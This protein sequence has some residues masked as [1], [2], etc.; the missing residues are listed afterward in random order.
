MVLTSEGVGDLQKVTDHGS[1]PAAPS[2]TVLSE[3]AILAA[4]E[5]ND[6]AAPVP[7]TKR[8]VRC[9]F[10][11]RFCGPFVHRWFGRWL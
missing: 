9:A 8:H 7:Q 4:Q 2:V 5:K 6:R 10:C 1:T 11:G 3:T